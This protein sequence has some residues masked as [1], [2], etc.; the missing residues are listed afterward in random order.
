MYCI[1]ILQIDFQTILFMCNHLYKVYSFG[2]QIILY[3]SAR[4]SEM[5]PRETKQPNRPNI[6]EVK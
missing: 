4:G 2:F 3:V 1:K 6:G 5:W